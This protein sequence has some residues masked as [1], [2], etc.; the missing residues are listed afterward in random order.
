MKV[1]IVTLY[2]FSNYGNVLQN[3]ALTRTLEDLGHEVTTLAISPKKLYKFVMPLANL[4]PYIPIAKRMKV[5]KKSTIKA[6]DYR[7]LDFYSKKKLRKLDAEFDAFVLGSDQVWNPKYISS[8]FISFLKFVAPEKRI[9][10]APSFGVSSL[11][12][13]LKDEFRDGLSGFSHLSVREI[14][15]RKLAEELCGKVAELDRKSVV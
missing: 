6:R 12:N 13:N 10:Y 9:A 5:S 2:D 14:E 15:G 8:K 7:I 4:A 3:Y 11:P 1:A